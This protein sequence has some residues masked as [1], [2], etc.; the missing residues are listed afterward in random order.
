[1][2]HALASLARECQLIHKLIYRNRNQQHSQMSFQL[3]RRV[4]RYTNRLEALKI[5]ELVEMFRGTLPSTKRAGE[6]GDGLMKGKLLPALPVIT[7]LLK[8]LLSSSELCK[9][10]TSFCED[11]YLRIAADIGKALFM[12]LN[13]VAIAA[14][15][16]V[17]VLVQCL[18][19]ALTHCYASWRPAIG[20]VQ[21]VRYREENRTGA[22]EIEDVHRQ[23]D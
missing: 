11:V 1:M 22:K 18:F 20:W 21:T 7:H 19:G 12:G 10:L 15:C 4:Y 16:R 13:V 5:V 17:N 9:Y 6:E 14:V 23:V 3:L 8:T 2:D